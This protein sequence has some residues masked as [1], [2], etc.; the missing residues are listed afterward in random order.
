MWLSSILLPD[1]GCVRCDAETL[2]TSRQ[3]P[4]NVIRKT[5]PAAVINRADQADNGKEGA[6]EYGRWHTLDDCL[7]V[8]TNTCS[9]HRRTAACLLWMDRSWATDNSLLSCWDPL[10]L[11]I[12]V[13]GALGWPLHTPGVFDGGPAGCITLSSHLLA[14]VLAAP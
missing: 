13:N 6:G 8:A 9:D 10:M 14:C 7:N 4:P 2:V 3:F 5:S 1:V 11:P 12:M